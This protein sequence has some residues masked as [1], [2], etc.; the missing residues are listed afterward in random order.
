MQM[1]FVVRLLDKDRNILAWNKLPVETR[2]DGGFWATQNFVAEAEA[3]GMAT[4]ICYH[5]PDL[6]VYQT[7]ALPE[8]VQCILGQ[9]IAIP[10]HN[11]AILTV[12]SEPL[13]LPAVTV[14]SNVTV[15]IGTGR[16]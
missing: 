9:T 13:P 10:I 15:G 11:T 2:G 7:V 6:H 5:W 16:G 12:P 4:G 14:R 1:M 3:T 8:P